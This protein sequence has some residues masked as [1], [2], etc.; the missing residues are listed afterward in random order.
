MGRATIVAKVPGEP[1]LYDV[2][3]DYGEAERDT[4]LDELD[5]EIGALTEQITGFQETLDAFRAHE[6]APAQ[7]AVD[8]A[9][10]VYIAASRATPADPDAVRAAT[11][12]HGV[13]LQALFD[14][15]V[16]YQQLEALLA[17]MRLR[18][19]AATRRRASLASAEVFE[20]TRAWCAD[21]TINAGGEVATIDVPGESGAAIIAP[22]AP[23][24]SAAAGALV[25]REL[26][27]GAQAFFNAALLPG[28]QRW[29]PTHRVGTVTALDRDANTASVTLDDARSS[30]QALPVDDARD[31]DAVPVHYMTCDARAFRVG[32]RVVVGFEEQDRARPTVIGFESRPR[33]CNV[34]YAGAEYWQVY[35]RGY[36][37]FV[38]LQSALIDVSTMEVVDRWDRISG[39]PGGMFAYNGQPYWEIRGLYF[40]YNPTD[41]PADSVSYNY[42][43]D[44]TGAQDYSLP[45]QASSLQQWEGRIYGI[46]Q[47]AT[48]EDGEYRLIYELNDDPPFSV[49]GSWL[50][51]G[52]TGSLNTLSVADGH[53]AVGGWLGNSLG[54]GVRVFD[55]RNGR[56]QVLQFV[57]PNPVES[58][59]VTRDYMAALHWG[60]ASHQIEL[61]R[62]TPGGYVLLQSITTGL[63]PYSMCI[64]G[65][66]IVAKEAER[67]WVWMIN[68]ATGAVTFRG[69]IRPFFPKG[70]LTDE[71]LLV[72]SGYR[73]DGSGASGHKVCAVA[74]S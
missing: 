69:E 21:Y 49:A 6:E 23:G 41:N 28:W 62:R 33:P 67:V 25:A 26:Q 34:V 27:S 39:F 47:G 36:R 48:G 5:A 42:L 9:V 16:R 11:D 59:W 56:A 60:G 15:Q 3:V 20:D 72:R 24:H 37:M 50:A 7:S 22:G 17:E 2:R 65:D 32:D 35:D 51:V 8:A 64:V 52:A 31:L 53:L 74:V 58:V 30:A 14:V 45:V 13:A 57:V 71:F 10:A 29:M 1:G 70:G 38:W 12:A 73:P 63:Y 66:Y 40:G 46:K 43:V 61:Y 19:V 54:Y 68:P 55:L 44:A 18:H 4:L